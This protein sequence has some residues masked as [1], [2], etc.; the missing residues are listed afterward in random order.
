MARWPKIGLKLGLNAMVEAS[1]LMYA[2]RWLGCKAFSLE[3]G[4]AAAKPRLNGSQHPSL[5]SKRVM[6]AE[7]AVL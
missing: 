2:T 3:V 7:M 5:G 6:L 1:A 4:L